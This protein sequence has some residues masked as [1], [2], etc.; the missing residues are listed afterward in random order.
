MDAKSIERFQQRVLS[1]YAQKGRELPWRETTDPYSILVSEVMLQQ[2]Q[3]DR[4]VPRY[5]NWLEKWPSVESLAGA[6][7]T[8]VL[9]EWMGLGYNSRAV[10]LHETAKVIV[11]QFNGNV[12]EALENHRQLPGIGPYTARAVEIFSA[13][14]DSAAV[15]TNIRRILIHEFSLKNPSDHELQSLAEVCLPRGRSRDWHNALMDYGSLV[16]TSRRTGIAP[17]TKQSRF[18]GSDRQVR[19]KVLRLLLDKQA[20]FEELHKKTDAGDRLRKI[21]EQMV[22]EDLL[23][24]KDKHYRVRD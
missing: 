17:K 23:V 3:V 1:Y 24:V 15:D 6:S 7:R 14:K 12:L 22:K 13:N 11:D 9:K 20:S 10:R 19:A 21:L 4:V 5:R 8:E 18:E 2:T 16:V